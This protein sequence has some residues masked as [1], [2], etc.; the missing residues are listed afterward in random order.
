MRDL[1]KAVNEIIEKP[2]KL[3]NLHST[4]HGFICSGVFIDDAFISADKKTS[5]CTTLVVNSMLGV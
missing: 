2:A 1:P 3:A 4:V 5:L